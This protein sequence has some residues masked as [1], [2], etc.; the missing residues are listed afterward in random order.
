V[1]A[2]GKTRLLFALAGE[3]LRRK[4]RVVTATTTKVWHWQALRAPSLILT[5]RDAKWLETVRQG[6][7]AHGHVFL[8]SAPLETGKVE[9]IHREEADRLYAEPWLEDLIVEADGASGLP[10]KAPAPHEPAVPGSCTMVV[11]MMGLD[12]LGAVVSPDRV[13]RAGH[14][15]ELTGLRTGERITPQAVARIFTHPQGLFRNCP[16]RA[17]RVV[18]L[19]KMDRLAGP[20]DLE[21]L[22]EALRGSTVRIDRVVAGSVQKADYIRMDLT[23]E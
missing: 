7:E 10:V 6:L 8:A 23:D 9:G 13:F 14:F 15:E 11:A 19:N 3:L 17:V 4:R 21:M 16:P 22:V 2:G 20:S 12:A 18:F 1:G 5:H